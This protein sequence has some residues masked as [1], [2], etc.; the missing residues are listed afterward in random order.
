MSV[1]TLVN[2]KAE[3]Y[4]LLQTGGTPTVSGVTVVYDHEPKKIDGPVAVTL[5]TDGMSPTEW[6]IALRL[7]ISIS[8]DQKA[9]WDSVDSLMPA[10]DHKIN[11]HFGPSDWTVERTEQGDYLVAT[12][13]L[14]VGRADYF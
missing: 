4:G 7:Y 6:R 3:L 12:N 11:A 1:D 8:A 5:S 10:V 14:E 13:I 9:G 2:A